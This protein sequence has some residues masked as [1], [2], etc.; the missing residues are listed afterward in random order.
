MTP[1]IHFRDSS[2][3]MGK[4]VLESPVTESSRT[5]S[6]IEY[7]ESKS[8]DYMNIIRTRSKP[9]KASTN[10]FPPQRRPQI[11][12]SESISSH[13]SS[14]IGLL[15]ALILLKASSSES[16]LTPTKSLLA[17]TK[18]LLTPRTVSAVKG[19]EQSIA[20]IQHLHIGRHVSVL[21][22]KDSPIVFR[23]RLTPLDSD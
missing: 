10:I 17:P 22:R 19:T 23:S 8:E 14:F 3:V 11:S 12:S 16:L 20:S 9:S 15:I 1:F 18:S 5:K 21:W 7:I 2:V 13:S 6:D 4:E